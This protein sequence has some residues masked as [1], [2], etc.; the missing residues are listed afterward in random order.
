MEMGL[1]PG[2][3]VRLVRVAPLG[4][5]IE[6]D[7]RGCRLSIRLQEAAAVRVQTET[8]DQIDDTETREVA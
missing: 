5:P 8:S 3:V 2:T 7:V 6:I 1:V 4:D